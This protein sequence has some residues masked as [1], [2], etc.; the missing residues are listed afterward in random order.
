[1]PLFSA[2]SPDPAGETVIAGDG[3]VR[4][5]RGWLE[6]SR[7]DDLLGKIRATT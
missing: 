1:M 4:L 6:R 3:D 7:A 5:Y 2:F